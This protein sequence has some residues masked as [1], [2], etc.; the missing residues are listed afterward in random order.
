MARST[1]GRLIVITT[2]LALRSPGDVA[3]ARAA[4]AAGADPDAIDPLNPFSLL[5]M[6]AGRGNVELVDALLR[7][8]ADPDRRSRQD[9]GTLCVSLAK[10]TPLDAAAFGK[11]PRRVATVK[12][13]LAPGA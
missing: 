5:V 10:P 3:A 12:R 2:W 13:L 1:F 8:G 7:A 11:T 6:V 9:I 4:L